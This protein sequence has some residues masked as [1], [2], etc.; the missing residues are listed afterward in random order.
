MEDAQRAAEQVQSALSFGASRANGALSPRAGRANRESL[1]RLIV[2]VALSPGEYRLELKVPQA[3][4]VLWL[5]DGRLVGAASSADG[6]SLLDRSSRDG[7]IDSRQEQ[8]LRLLRAESTGSMARVLRERGYLR[9]TEVVPLIQRHAEQIALEAFSEYEVIYRLAEESPS[10]D[11][12]LAAS[13][14]GPLELLAEG[15][16]RGFAGEPL[17]A[18]LGGLRA[19]PRLLE[20]QVT[21][22]LLGLNGRERE[23]LHAVD[24]EASLERLMLRAGLPQERA[25]RVL[26]LARTVGLIELEAAPAPDELP[27]DLDVAAP[28]LE[29]RRGAGGR[30]L[31][32]PRPSALGRRRRGAACLR[33][34]CK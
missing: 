29:V 24:G 2:E 23:L 11:V 34:P 10:A 3:L 22:E 17:L 20:T 7:L 33:A 18:H 31:L 1:A 21:P 13:A 12:A 14:R 4:R 8:E 5:A 32:R 27:G 25:L 15:L 30:L 9:E 26:M 28:R 16:R 6:E 19:V